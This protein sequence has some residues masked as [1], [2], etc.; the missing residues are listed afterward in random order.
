MGKPVVC[1]YTCV[2]LLVVGLSEWKTVCVNSTAHHITSVSLFLCKHCLP[3]RLSSLW[4]ESPLHPSAVSQ[5][6][7]FTF[8][9]RDG[10]QQHGLVGEKSMSQAPT[11]NRY[12]YCGCAALCCAIWWIE[13]DVWEIGTPA[14]SE[15]WRRKLTLLLQMFLPVWEIT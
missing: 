13:T 7:H 3:V 8:G 5:I 10:L 4:V 15:D 11:G 14:C 6:T 9:W 2:C 12:T 1:V